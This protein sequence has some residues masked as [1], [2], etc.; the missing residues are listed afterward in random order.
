[1]WCGTQLPPLTPLPF[2]CTTLCTSPPHVP[3]VPH[4]SAPC[5]PC[6]APH[7]YDAVHISAALTRLPKLVTYREKDLVESG[8]VAPRGSGMLALLPADG[9][10]PRKGGAERARLLAKRLC[11]M[12]PHHAHRMYPR[13]VCAERNESCCI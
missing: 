6:D 7:R 5:D 12:I 1:M 4:E 3:H 8:V 9:A 10:S 11:T 2:K 13:Q